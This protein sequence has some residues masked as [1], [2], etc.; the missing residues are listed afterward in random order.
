MA[1]SPDPTDVAAPDPF[2]GR[3][4]ELD[5]LE[6]LLRPSQLVDIV[7]PPGVGKSALA[8]E[9]VR[10]R[11]E[12]IDERWVVVEGERCQSAAD[13]V[14]A[15]AEACSIEPAGDVTAL[16]LANVVGT[17]LETRGLDG[18]LLDNAGALADDA[19]I[20]EALISAGFAVRWL[21]TTR[22]P[23]D[24]PHTET[25]RLGPLDPAPAAALYRSVADRYWLGGESLRLDDEPVQR[26]VDRLGRHPTAIETAASRINV[27]TPERLLERVETGEAGEALMDLEAVPALETML[28]E[29]WRDLDPEVRQLLDVVA[30]FAGPAS[31]DAIEG[32]YEDLDQTGSPAALADEL[33]RAGWLQ[34]RKAPAR[35]RLLHLPTT[36]KSFARERLRESGRFEAIIQHHA[37]SVIA[38]AQHLERIL[39]DRGGRSNLEE[40]KE[41]SSEL[42]AVF[43]RFREADPQLAVESL[44]PLR[45]TC[46]LGQ[47]E[48]PVR[49][50]MRRSVTAE[51]LD[52]A[53][54]RD[55]ALLAAFAGELEHRANRTDSAADRTADALRRLPNDAPVSAVSEV[56]LASSFPLATI[57]PQEASR[58][59]ERALEAAERSRR[60]TLL[61]RVRERLGFAALEDFDLESARDEFNRARSL[62]QEADNPLFLP[63]ILTGLGYVAHRLD[64]FESARTAFEEAIE[65]YR[66]AGRQGGAGGARFN[67][68]VVLLARGE[69][70][71]AIEQLRRATDLLDAHGRPTQCAAARVRL[72]LALLEAGDAERAKTHFRDALATA[73]RAGDAHNQA[74]AE[75]VLTI[76]GGS[77]RGE[78]FEIPLRDLQAASE[79]DAAATFV[80]YAAVC[81][82]LQS[83]STRVESKLVRLDE[84]EHLLGPDD[85]YLEHVIRSIRTGCLRVLAE[86]DSELAPNPNPAASDVDVT[87]LDNP[88]GRLV[89][90]AFEEIQPGSVTHQDASSRVIPAEE[91]KALQLRVHRRGHWFSVDGGEPVDLTSRGPLRRLLAEIVEVVD[92]PE[93]RGA[94]VD[95]LIEA[96][97]PEATP[98]QSSGANRVYYSIRQLRELGLE[99]ILVTGEEGYCFAETTELRISSS[100][101]DDAF[102]SAR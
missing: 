41:L 101:Y 25:L 88:L 2:V 4:G 36:L 31:L 30:A 62:L 87:D 21:A 86:M 27:L 45:W 94:T 92:D 6:R 17:R 66:A 5:Q 47:L 77:R 70:E 90:R 63:S 13:V 71:A 22:S 95:D 15:V 73:Q 76:L 75:G 1:D 10:R 64:M 11:R 99:E 85:S 74:L 3:A 51:F 26:L 39:V 37:E 14:A 40:L 7:G 84:L 9:F 72:G 46:R 33:V 93:R 97:W 60:P 20:T 54:Q 49:T 12:S 89:G 80:A 59:L 58:R 102:V 96:G 38:R 44:L 8:R 23:V 18:I 53:R 52:R 83:E 56:Y 98:T 55:A 57:D 67:L 34:P 69:I 78:Q 43:D 100:P 32:L 68:G 79:P 61:A 16:E 50:R 82:A 24:S 42:F 28:T 91:E 29:A 48:T 19:R 65:G 81:F 35:G